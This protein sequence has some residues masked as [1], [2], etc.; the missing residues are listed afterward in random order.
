MSSYMASKKTMELNP[1]HPIIIALRD[2]ASANAS[3]KTI[4]DLIWLMFDTAMLTAGFSLDESSLFANRIHRLIKLG[5]S[6]DD[7]EGGAME[8]DDAPPPL[9]SVDDGNV[10]GSTMEAVD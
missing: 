8:D 2:K 9:E 5:L 7:I 1:T 10:E 4:K 3:D 6:I